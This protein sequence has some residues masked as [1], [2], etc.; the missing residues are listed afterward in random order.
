MKTKRQ[1]KTDTKCYRLGQLKKEKKRLL[2]EWKEYA[3]TRDNY[4]CCICGKDKDNCR[5]NVHHIISRQI[6]KYKT[7]NNNS[8]TLCANHHLFS[9]ELSAHKQSIAFFN[10]LEHN[11]PL[12]FM[13]AI[14]A[15]KTINS[16][17]DIN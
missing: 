4:K 9:K 8:I 7:D 14:T 2:E 10:W 13:W 5:L 11:R 17:K 16:D 3:L 15:I 6:T 1:I 12:Q